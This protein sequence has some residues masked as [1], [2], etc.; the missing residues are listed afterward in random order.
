MKPSALQ[1]TKRALAEDGLGEEK[2][3]QALT[4]DDL[5]F[6]FAD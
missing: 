3:A 6:L 2:F 1:K 4:L 5:R